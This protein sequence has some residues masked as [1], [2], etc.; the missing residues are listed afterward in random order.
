[1]IKSV[2]IECIKC[3]QKTDIL[4]NTNY[5]YQNISGKWSNCDSKDKKISKLNMLMQLNRNSRSR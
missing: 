2:T 3:G 1:M 5:R 4:S